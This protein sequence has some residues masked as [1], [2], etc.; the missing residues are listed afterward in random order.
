MP[1]GILRDCHFSHTTRI[2]ELGEVGQARSKR[3][4]VSWRRAVIVV[5]FVLVS[6]G[7]LLSLAFFIA[8]PSASEADITVLPGQLQ[9]IGVIRQQSTKPIQFELLNS[10]AEP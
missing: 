5:A 9:N 10:S 2:H 3:T 7:S 4:Q 6:S 8:Y 1:I